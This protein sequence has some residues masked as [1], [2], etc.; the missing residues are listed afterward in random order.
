MVYYTQKKTISLI[1]WEFKWEVIFMPNSNLNRSTLSLKQKQKVMV[2]LMFCLSETLRTSIAVVGNLMEANREIVI[3]NNVCLSDS[4]KRNEQA[5]KTS[6]DDVTSYGEESIL[7]E[8][9]NFNLSVVS[10]KLAQN[11]YSGELFESTSVA[12]VNLSSL[13]LDDNLGSTAGQEDVTKVV[14][15][16]ENN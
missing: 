3:E 8:S 6:Y 14:M 2:A 9:E 15:T 4:G 5:G 16:G 1:I 11:P 13:S 7:G 12:I 10:T